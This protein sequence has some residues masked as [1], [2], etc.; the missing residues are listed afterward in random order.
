MDPVD[1]WLGDLMTLNIADGA[2]VALQI[3]ANV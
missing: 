3:V 2:A 1:R